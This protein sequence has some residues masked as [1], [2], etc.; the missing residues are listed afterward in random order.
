[1][2]IQ[3]AATAFATVLLAFLVAQGVL[4]SPLLGRSSRFPDAASA[5]RVPI[6][7]TCLTRNPQRLQLSNLLNLC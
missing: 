4:A 1:M 2:R 5:T 6:G 3:A 7:L